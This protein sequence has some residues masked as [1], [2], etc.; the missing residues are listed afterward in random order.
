MDCRAL[1]LY[2]YYIWSFMHSPQLRRAD[3]EHTFY[4][5]IQIL[6]PYIYVMSVPALGQNYPILAHKRASKMSPLPKRETYRVKSIIILWTYSNFHI[7]ERRVV[8]FPFR[9][10]LFFYG[11]KDAQ[12]T[13]T[14]FRPLGWYLIKCITIAPSKTMFILWTGVKFV[15]QYT[16][17]YD[18]KFWPVAS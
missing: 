3:V 8:N 18:V 6:E 15:S 11:G 17:L 14:F 1:Y 13:H 10:L 5:E 2:P 4:W 12:H 9:F 7:S 16:Q